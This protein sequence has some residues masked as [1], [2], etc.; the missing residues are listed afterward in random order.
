MKIKS[1]IKQF[2]RFQ[3]SI[4]KNTGLIPS[5]LEKAFRTGLE[6]VLT[7][8]KTKYLTGPRPEKLG[9]VT[10]RLRSSI[11][12]RLGIS[13]GKISGTVGTN[14]NYA[15]I[16]EYGG[17]IKPT[18]RILAFGKKGRF[19]S[20]KKAGRMKTGAV[21]IAVAQYKERK[22]PARPFVEPGVKESIPKIE[23][24][25]ESVGYILQK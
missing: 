3:K 10:G 6:Y 22:M 4:N 7:T 16:H 2:V 12:Y 25:L 11:F 9:V 23:R 19:I 15:A 5:K 13:L 24:L 21:R 8:I 17:V 20:R 14:V 18:T 1:D